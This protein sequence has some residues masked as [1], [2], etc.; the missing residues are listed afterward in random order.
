MLDIQMEMLVLFNDLVPGIQKKHL[1]YKCKFVSVHIDSL[2][3]HG[4]IRLPKE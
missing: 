3:S 4:F 1:D 2:C